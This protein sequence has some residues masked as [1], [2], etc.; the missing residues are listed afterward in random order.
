MA[1]RFARAALFVTLLVTPAWAAAGQDALAAVYADVLRGNWEAGRTRVDQ[2]AA[3]GDEPGASRLRDWLTAYHDVVASRKDLK[4]RSF[5]WNLE[6]ARAA[7]GDDKLY[8]ALTFALQ[9][10]AYA[11]D[12]NEFAATPWVT[13]LIA[14]AKAAALA[15][16][17]QGQ[18]AAA[19][20][21]YAALGRIRPHDDE[22]KEL[23]E[24][25]AR[26]ARLEVTYKDEESLREHIRDVDKSLFRATVK[27]I[28]Q[29][30]YQEPDFR[31]LAEGGLDNLRTLCGIPKVHKFLDGLA[32][33]A[34]REH[35]E[36]RL[37]ELRTDL[38]RDGEFDDKDVV[39]LFNRVL[40][41][42]RE[43][44]ELPEGVIVAEFLE[45]MVAEL[46]DY[47]GMIWPSDSVD[48]DKAM[49]GGFEGVGIQL[50][51]DERSNRLKVVTP[52]ENSPALEAGVQPEDL[53]VSVNGESTV[54]WSSDDAVRK[55]AGPAGTSVDL[56]ILRPTS[57][58]ELTYRLARRRIVITTVRGL[59][60]VPGSPK[61]WNYML[62]PDAGVAYIR[63]SNFHPDSG[64]ELSDALEQART[65]GMKGLVLDIRH[66][67]GGLLDVA[68]EIVSLF[69][70]DGEVVS[71][72]GRQ[73]SDR[74]TC[75]PGKAR[76]A[77]IPLVVLVNEHSASASEI[78][79]GALQDHQRAL[80]L[81]ER[82]F[83]KGSVQHVQPLSDKARIKLTTALYYLP[84]GRSPHKA[85]HA[86]RWGV[87]PDWELRLT[88]KE[89]RR[90]VERERAAYII[91]NEKQDDANRVLSEEERTKRVDAVKS[92]DEN[93]D[94]EPPLLSDAEIKELEKDP[95][96][97]PKSDPQLET[98]LLLVRV[99]LAAG[100]PWPREF[101]AAARAE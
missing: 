98:A 74:R 34:L 20:S 41:V 65:Q 75:L 31:R 97:A 79:A 64:R 48:F 57:G 32:N 45:G 8:L 24:H 91:H 55:I 9:A 40:D 25:A 3:Q 19:L 96:E 42:N 47:T 70:G 50:G 14:Q 71:T 56:T 13:E 6:Q 83:G 36:R 38:S 51:V 49:M 4:A 92:G 78:L 44:V 1:L 73:E 100:M 28:S 85:P 11:A 35:F 58:E 27:R 62:D 5:E 52:L 72:R 67:P 76:Y 101:V 90:V 82:T 22:L 87:D 37:A 59:D 2:L 26:R 53:I 12:P 18:W 10:S 69:V 46:D 29:L 66:N 77:D 60:R 33:P 86:E 23:S 81:G 95:H 16:E 54:G 93:K 80:V 17:E 7:L 30:Y 89:F 15:R 43:S 99:K 39:R 61:T 21:Y 84:S 68:V 63:L 94:D 88:P